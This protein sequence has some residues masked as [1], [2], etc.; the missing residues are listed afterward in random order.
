MVTLRPYQ[1]AAIQATLAYWERGGGNPLIDMATGLGKSVVIAELTRRLLVDYPAM[2]VLMLVHV[3]ELVEQNYM[4]LRRLWPDAAAG[5]YSAGLNRRDAHSRITFASIQSVYKRARELGPR[6]LVLIDEA[7]LVPH[8]G[9]GMYRALLHG[10]RQQTPDLRV[11]GLTATPYRLDSGRLDQGDS[12]LFDEVVY[13]YDIGAGIRD[14]WLSPLTARAT[15]TEID[16]SGVARRG[17]EFVAGALEAAADIDDLTQAAVSDM[18][19]LAHDR[20]S[21]LV[22]CSGVR[23]AYNVAAALNAR[24]VEAAVVTGETPAGERAARI[25]AFKAGRIRALCNAQVLT[26]GFDAP[27]TDM[28]A[29]LRATL[30]TGLYI[31]MCGRGTRKAEGKANCLVLD[32]AGNVRRHGPVD[33]VVEPSGRAQKKSGEDEVKVQVDTVRAKTCPACGTLNQLSAAHCAECDY[34]WPERRP[35]HR[36]QADTEAALLKEQI[37]PTESPVLRWD[38]ARHVAREEGKIDTL[39]VTYFCGLMTHSE[40]L[41]FEHQGYPRNKAEAWWK[42]HANTAP[43]A[44]IA[45]ALMRQGELRAP[46]S[47]FVQPDGKW[48]RV[49]GR[50]FSILEE[51][52]A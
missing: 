12:R 42:A 30:S 1:D 9:D 21:W 36:E 24:G 38:L 31:Q 51:S 37:K 23:H 46:A 15:A 4:A 17:G 26:T 41:C 50:R 19:R 16:V 34:E 45:E 2:R 5:I 27:N 40:W 39:R 20:R 43:P 29:F 14:G 13:S 32:F 35:S 48:W 22:F 6:D 49:V 18:L 44:T 25:A 28:I 47:V 3:K 8:A 7:H 10:L 11:A 33:A 52:A